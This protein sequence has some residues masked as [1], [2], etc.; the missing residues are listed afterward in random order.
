MPS[1]APRSLPSVL[2]LCPRLR[3][4]ARRTSREVR[5]LADALLAAF[6]DSRILAEQPAG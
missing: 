3:W 1:R 6:P 5:R 4:R 2:D